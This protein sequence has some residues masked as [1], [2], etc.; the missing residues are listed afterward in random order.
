MQS[1]PAENLTPPGSAHPPLYAVS[2]RPR[3]RLAYVPQ[4]RTLHVID[5]ENLMGGPFAGLSNM[6]ASADSYREQIVLLP[7]DHLVVAVNPKLA[8]QARQCWPEGKLVTGGGPNGADRALL[9]ELTDF[10]WIASH[11]DRV[12][13]G[14]GDGIFEDAASSLVA[15]GIAVG[16]ASRRRSLAHALAAR[17]TFIRY[18]P[19]TCTQVRPA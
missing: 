8:I 15:L 10:D 14:S 12:V 3:S 16:V 19:E 5:V 4:G 2:L 18:L 6:Q 1:N 7:Q 11:Y 13:L 17:A 9:A